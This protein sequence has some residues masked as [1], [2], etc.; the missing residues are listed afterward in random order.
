M[1]LQVLFTV[2]S[3]RQLMEQLSSDLLFRW[4]VGLNP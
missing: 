1:L 3:E 4:F 2:R